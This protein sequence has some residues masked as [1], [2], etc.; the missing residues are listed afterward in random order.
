VIRLRRV[1]VR[2]EGG[3]G[4]EGDRVEA[5]A[6][7][8]GLVAAVRRWSS[9]RGPVEVLVGV[10]AVGVLLVLVA[11]AAHAVIANSDSATVVLEGKA[12]AHGNLTLSGWSLSLD[13]FWS[14]DAVFYAIGVAVLGLRLAV[15]TLVPAVIGLFVVVLGACA[16]RE[17]LGGKA[18][19]AAVLTVVALLALPS[20]ALAFFFLQGPWHIATAL[21]C[22]VAFVAVRDGRFGWGTV[23]AA[24]FLAAGL[25]GDLQ[26][27]GLG[28]VPIAAAGLIAMCRERNWR[29]GVAE[30]AAAVA[31]VV[32]AIVVRVVTS[33]FGAFS[34]H[35]S[36]HTASFARM[37]TNLGHLGAWGLSLLGVTRGPYGGPA[38]PL[39]IAL[40]HGLGAVV[41]LGSVLVALLG[42]VRGVLRGSPGPEWSWRL[43]DLLVLGCLGDL[44]VFE[45]L[46]LSDNTEYARYLT[47]GLIFAVVLAGRRVGRVVSGLADGAVA[48]AAAALGVAVM[49]AFGAEVVTEVQ[50][51]LPT[52][53]IVALDRLL[54]SKG[55][56]HGV[57][58]YWAASVVTV[59]SHGAVTIRPIVANLHHVL[60]A[61][62]RQADSAWYAGQTFQFLVYQRLP[63]GRVDA[64]TVANT[65][66]P[67]VHTFSVGSYFV[68]VWG[69]PLRLPAGA[70]P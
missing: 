41:V 30:V 24:V 3:D 63:Y 60:V 62:G 44:V 32:L 52:Q 48:R 40:A 16:A 43:D 10:S 15:I 59:E 37:G 6:T 53:P 5:A 26:T 42:A 4:G 34:F 51:P 29:S 21:W 2:P 61:D 23:V 65:F 45:T 17:R 47:A 64:A 31:G 67:P 14:V 20:H 46:T 18:A 28:V 7:R 33:Y 49:V 27:V 9:G 22:L 11:T 54:A 70:Y 66:G 13:S 69:H 55:L 36:H 38:V 68:D 58:D 1:R 25:L 35:E 12:I 50:A 19:L 8:G 56:T 39:V 57:G